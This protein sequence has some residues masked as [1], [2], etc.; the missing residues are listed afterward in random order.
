[1]IIHP[2]KIIQGKKLSLWVGLPVVEKK[3][4]NMTAS[5]GKKILTLLPM[6]ELVWSCWEYGRCLLA[7]ALVVEEPRTP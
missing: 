3:L 7:L 4:L 2:R 1:L 5:T 6:K